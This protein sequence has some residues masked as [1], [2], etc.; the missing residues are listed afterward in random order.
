MEKKDK[1]FFDW[2]YFVNASK[3]FYG[4]N[5][6]H[7][8]GGE[9]S[10]HP[11]FS[12]I[13]AKFK[14]LFNCRLLTIETNGT[15]LRSKSESF[16]YFDKIYISHYTKDT[17]NGCPDNTD[18]INYIKEYLKD[19]QTEVIVGEVEHISREIRG[20]KICP[21][22]TSELVE[23]NNGKI[24]PCCVGSGLDEDVCIRPTENWIE[25]IKLVMPPCHICF[26]AL[27]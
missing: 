22:G 26:F 24:Y 7:L 11:D 1:K 15:L 12:D 14:E 3:Y 23:Y 13:A 18:N 27:P 25:E 8:S 4:M 17:F 9:P 2:E 6:I 20:T 19:S 10:M 16:K 5:R 21:R